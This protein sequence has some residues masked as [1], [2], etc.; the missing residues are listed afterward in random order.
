M[1]PKNTSKTKKARPH[2]RKLKTSGAE[3][4]RTLAE[5]RQELDARNRDL[6]ESSQRERAALQKLQDRDQQLAEALEQQIATS[7]VLKIISQSTFDLQLVLET[8]VETVVRLFRSAY[9]VRP[10]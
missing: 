6:G 4:A 10:A 3:Q 5:L 8:L 7:E 2:N 1:A 9:L